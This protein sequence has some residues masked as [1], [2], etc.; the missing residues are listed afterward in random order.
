[1]SNPGPPG[2]DER[3]PAGPDTGMGLPESG[4]QHATSTDFA[5]P[6]DRPAE[7]DPLAGDVPLGET[8]PP[9][10]PVPPAY[11]DPTEL[12]EPAGPA[13][14]EPTDL[15]DAVPDVEA[16][17]LAAAPDVAGTPAYDALATETGFT[18]PA[19]PAAT[20]PWGGE[21]VLA[22]VKAFADQRPAAFLAAALV[23]GWLVG[24]LLGSSGDDDDE[25]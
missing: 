18:D 10:Q 20:V 8:P 9:A 16:A 17:E 25:D 19:E 1:M 7:P 13:D 21:G 3:P 23:A 24:K 15:L 22:K 2:E 12:V 6:L 14:D 11:E 4:T 5:L